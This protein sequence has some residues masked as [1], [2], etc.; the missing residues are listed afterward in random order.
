M[1]KKYGFVILHYLA[2]EMTT[3]C[4]DNILDNFNSKSIEIVI[5]DNASPNGSGK[6]LLE[7][8]AQAENVIVLLN[9]QNSGFARGNNVGYSFL[10]ENKSCDYIIVMNNDVLIEQTNFLDI[11][12]ELYIK[13]KF[14]VLGPDIYCPAW[15]VRQ[16]PARLKGLSPQRVE[17]LCNSYQR[18]CRHPVLHY[19]KDAITDK[20]K[21]RTVQQIQ[22]MEKI[23]RDVAYSNVVLHG[24]C[25]IFSPLFINNRA[26]AFC[27]DTFL[28]MEEDILHFE[29]NTLNLK[30]LYSP[31]IKVTHLEEV[32]TS[33]NHKTSYSKK[34]MKYNETM[35]SLRVLKNLMSKEG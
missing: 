20:L 12:D 21:G 25:Y 16:N 11:I 14:A 1:N 9:S 8:Y 33:S 31:R 35:K 22:G 7:K 3:Q 13:N 23:D 19:C 18:W 4:V 24:A 26:R 28:Y 6:R 5:V 27:P 17:S 15:N 34:K 30:M 29:C 10:R 2:E 32:S